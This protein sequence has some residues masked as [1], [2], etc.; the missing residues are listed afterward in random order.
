M[1]LI[2]LKFSR[3]TKPQHAQATMPPAGI[4]SPVSLRAK[5]LPV[6]TLGISL[7]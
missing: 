7:H 1:S 2:R 5:H 4:T 6:P 3:G